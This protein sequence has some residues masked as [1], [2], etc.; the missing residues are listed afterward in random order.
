MA[1]QT[2]PAASSG[3]LQRLQARLEGLPAPGGPMGQAIAS[4]AKAQAT[5]FAAFDW[6]STGTVEEK[7]EVLRTCMKTIQEL[8]GMCGASD[9]R[10]KILRAMHAVA[11]AIVEGRPEPTEKELGLTGSSCFIATAACGAEDAPE[12]MRLRSFRDKVLRRSR[13]GRAFVRAY[14][15]LSPPIAQ[16]IRDKPL[17][18]PLVR[19][20]VVFPAAAIVRRWVRD[21][22][23]A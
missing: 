22:D 23:P 8:A 11:T 19:W 6:A 21:I 18:G 16:F 7:R 13:G 10:V 3:L 2:P 1:E 12:V 20:A 17:A 4:L 14:E 15:F 5:A 9:P